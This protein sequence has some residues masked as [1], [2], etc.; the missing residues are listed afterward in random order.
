MG[1]MTFLRNRAGYILVGAIAFAIIA[2]IVGDVIN[3]GKP[4]WAASQRVVGTIDGVDVNIDEFGQKV[5]QN[6]TQFKQQYGNSVNPQMQAMAVDNA[7]QAEIGNVLLTKEYDRLGLAVSGDELFDLL[8]GSNPSPLILQYFGNPQTG[9][10]D[11][12]AVISSLKAQNTNPQLKEQ[13]TML[14]QEIEKQALQQKYVNLIRNSVYVTSLEANEDY[15]SRNKLANFRYVSLNYNTLSDADVKLSDAD[16]QRFYDEHKMMFNNPAETRSFE[17]VNFSITP[18]HADSVALKEQMT[19]M[20]ADFKV[21]PNDSLFAANNSDVKVPFNYIGKGKLDPAV[22]S[23]IF[24]YPVGSYY[25]PVFSGN[26]Y[27]LVKVVDSRFSPDSVKASHILIDPAKVGGEAQALKMADSL[28]NLVQKGADFAALA[29]TYSVD[30]SKDQGGDLGTFA[31]GIMVPEFENAA[32]NGKV[33]DYRIVKTQF[34]IHLV[35]IVKQIGSS[36][37]AKLAYIEKVL[38][39]SSKTRDAAYKK[40]SV[41]LS[42]VKSDNFAAVAKKYNYVV[43]VGDRVSASQGFLAGLE[44]PRPLIRAVYGA[45]TGDVLEEIFNMDNG[46]VVAHVTGIQ[47]KG[48]L[49]LNDVKSQIEGAV[50]TAKKGEILID[51][52]NKALSGA[53]NIDQVAQKIGQSVNPIENIVLANPVLPGVAQENKLIGAVFGSPVGKVSK[54]IEGAVGVYAFVVDGFSKPAALDNVFKQK[55]AMAE[56]NVQRSLGA[57]FQALQDKAEIKDNR[58]KFY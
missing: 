35:H 47:P 7:W 56:G 1:L 19:K 5:E 36:K 33:G 24:N 53:S 52:M 29:K 40:A 43:A 46:Y 15:M 49:A 27:K 9:Q 55:Q 18:T 44:S 26:S 41:F 32:F 17:Y 57:A 20:A 14:Q 37:V 58:V 39:P 23:V 3:T 13:W 8:Q 25:G 12:A 34:G 48:Q 4:F 10:F 42:E 50:R 38:E 11:R 2:F 30:G 22:D 31:R 21:T 6:L 51:K 45:K 54:A 16:Y 28:K